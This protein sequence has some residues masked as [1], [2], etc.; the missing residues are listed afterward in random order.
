[1]LLLA[2]VS[3]PSILKAPFPLWYLLPTYLPINS[4]FL[5]VLQSHSELFL[6]LASKIKASSIR[7]HPHLRAAH[8]VS[9][10]RPRSE[11]TRPL[12]SRRRRWRHC[13]G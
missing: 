4:L 13:Q 1:M 11:D 8:L 3:D 2:L 9:L 7:G 5:L 10:E 6:G 12:S